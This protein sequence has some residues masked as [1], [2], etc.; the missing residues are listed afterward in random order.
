M[1]CTA[2]L[3]VFAIHLERN[4]VPGVP[5]RRKEVAPG[6]IKSDEARMLAAGWL[7]LDQGGLSGFFMDAEN[8]GA[9]IPAIGAVEES[10]VRMNFDLRS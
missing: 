9:V 7:D 2:Q 1:F 3:S 4:N 10:T 5:V 6:R 8:S